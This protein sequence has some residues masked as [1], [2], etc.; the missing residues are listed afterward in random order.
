MTKKKT[1][2][3][4]KSVKNQKTSSTDDLQVQLEQAQQSAKDSLDKAL[5]ASAEVENM[6]RRNIID[7]ENAHKFAL[8]NFAKALLEVKDSLT[9]GLKTAKQENANIA[10][11]IEGLEITDKVFLATLEKFGIEAISP[12]DEVFDPEFHEAVTMIPMPDKKSNTVLEVVQVGF[13]LNGRL[14][15]PAMVVVAQ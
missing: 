11:V 3:Q 7:L 8:D 13:S 14:M 6:K 1:E 10:S 15:R 9:M 12:E 5:R 4:K 2:S